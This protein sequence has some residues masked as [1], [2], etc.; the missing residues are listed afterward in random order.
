M[1]DE[2]LRQAPVAQKL[3]S[4]FHRIKRYPV[5][6]NFEIRLRYLLHSNLSSGWHYPQLGPCG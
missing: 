5:D 1:N 4:A 3:D 2:H 6:K